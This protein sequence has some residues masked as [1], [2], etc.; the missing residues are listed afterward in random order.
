MK[1][2]K[3]ERKNKLILNIDN[4]YEFPFNINYI[5]RRIFE[6]TLKIEKINVAASINIVIVD[7]K[8]IKKVNK[9]H[10]DINKITD[11]LSFPN[12]KIDKPSDFKKI[13]KNKKLYSSIYD[14]YSNTIFLGDVMICYDKIISQ[15]ENYGHSIKREYSFLLTH[16]ILHLLGYDHIKKSDEMIMFKKQDEI[17]NSLNI[18][19]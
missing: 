6:E 3:K 2:L 18:K 17:L 13:L 10:R 15:S 11:V 19:R 16:S 8:T 1:T 14:Y 5:S 7:K 4:E 9:E 12:I